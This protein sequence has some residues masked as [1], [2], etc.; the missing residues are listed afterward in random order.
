MLSYVVQTGNVLLRGGVC[1]TAGA[2]VLSIAS[3][4]S[5]WETIIRICIFLQL[6]GYVYSYDEYCDTHVKQIQLV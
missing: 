4:V 6:L 2:L 5:C 1:L 3:L